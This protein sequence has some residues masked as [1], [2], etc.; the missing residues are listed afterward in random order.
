MITKAKLAAGVAS[1]GAAVALFPAAAGADV[2][3]T[4]CGGG[5]SGLT[6]GLT[7]I[8]STAAGSTSG[9]Q[10]AEAVI[11]DRLAGNHNETVLTLP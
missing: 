8:A 4:A 9:G 6:T 7:A 10:I 1:A 11:L 2:W 5:D 3:V